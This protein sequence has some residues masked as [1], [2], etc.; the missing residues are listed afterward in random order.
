MQPSG[1][2]IGIVAD[3]L[4][5]ACDTALQFYEAGCQTRVIASYKDL[6]SPSECQQTLAWAFNTESRHLDIH[7]AS[8]AI[9]KTAA[10]M[11]DYFSIDRIYKKMDSTLR[12]NIAHECLAMLDELGYECAVIAPA[13]PAEGRRTVGGYQLVRGIPVE[14]TE[15]ARDPLFPVYESHIPRLLAEATKEEIVG[16]IELS[17]VMRGAGPIIKELTEKIES[18]RK[19]VVID[20]CTQVDM[21]QIA[22]AIDKIRKHHSVL[23]CGSAGLAQAMSMQWCGEIEGPLP[24]PEF[25]G[26]SIFI[27]AGS[28]AE[29][30]RKQ[31]TKLVDNFPYYGEGTQL[32]VYNVQPEQILSQDIDSLVSHVLSAMGDEQA[33]NTVV[34]ALSLKDDNYARTL[35]LGK[36]QG[37]DETQVARLAEHLLGEVT[38]TIMNRRQCKLVVCGGETATEVAH[39]L[40]IKSFDI[41]GQ[42]EKVLP[43]MKGNSKSHPEHPYWLITKSGNFGSPLALANIVKYLKQH[44]TEAAGV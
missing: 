20:A 23:P 28:N 38:K 29:G 43:L 18:G 31:I 13:F 27:V 11:K 25:P 9:R 22:L 17:T 8:A 30:T 36:G 42:V 1:L 39:A 15:I 4:T 7:E 16:H 14:R 6:P 5:G 19:L 41:I 24:E 37:L 3:D 10:A 35:E 44:E 2:T 26:T 34:L 40:D 21:E 12:G 32:Q 33:R